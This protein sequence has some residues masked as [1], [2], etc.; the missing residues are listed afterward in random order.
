MNLQNIRKYNKAVGSF[1]NSKLPTGSQ[2]YS[3]F[4]KYSNSNSNDAIYCSAITVN[5]IEYSVMCNSAF[6]DIIENEPTHEFAIDSL[7]PSKENRFILFTDLIDVDP[8]L[9]V[10]DINVLVVKMH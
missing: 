4:A 3:N 6:L 8:G 2:T 1:S 9:V 7:R 5:G 10:L